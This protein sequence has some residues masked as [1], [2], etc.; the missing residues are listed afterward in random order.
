MDA[1]SWLNKAAI[2][3]ATDSDYFSYREFVHS[4]IV[5][6]EQRRSKRGVAM[7][8]SQTFSMARDTVTK[9][10]TQLQWLLQGVE[11]HQRKVTK[12]DKLTVE[13]M[14]YFVYH[15]LLFRLFLMLF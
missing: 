3:W 13:T 4:K 6:N 8:Q 11:A 1:S 5:A 10:D 2:E 9:D 14:F 12:L 15:L 7:I